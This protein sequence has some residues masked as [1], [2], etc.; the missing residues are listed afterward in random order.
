MTIRINLDE[1]RK[2]A[3][4]FLQNKIYTFINEYLPNG[5]E[6]Q[7]N[8]FIVDVKSD[9]TLVFFDVVK[10][11]LIYLLLASCSIDYSNGKVI[12]EDGA[13]KIMDGVLKESENGKKKLN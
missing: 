13:K 10:V 9:D 11:K 8:G 1:N 6:H 4:L 5:I 2:R 12:T 7:Y 3:K